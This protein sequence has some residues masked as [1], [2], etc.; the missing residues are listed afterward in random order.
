MSS[1]ISVSL[2]L[3]F[4]DSSTRVYTI[5]D[6]SDEDVSDVKDNIIAVNANAN[7]QYAPLY[8]TFVSPSGF[9][10]VNISAAKITS[11]EEDVIYNG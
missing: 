9:S 7:G 4:A 8:Q 10:F 11:V 5:E 1:Q 6:V 2:T 3:S